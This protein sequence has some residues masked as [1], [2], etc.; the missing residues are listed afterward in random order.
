[1]HYKAWKDAFGKCKVIFYDEIRTDSFE[2]FLK[3]A[4][5]RPIPDIPEIEP[6]QV[7]LGI[8]QMAF[9]L[10]MGKQATVDEFMCYRSASKRASQHFKISLKAKSTLLLRSATSI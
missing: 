2:N 3:A 5:L 6:I 1:M 4:G 7:S 9:L 8:Y 10:R